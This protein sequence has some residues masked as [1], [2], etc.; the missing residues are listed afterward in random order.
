MHDRTH[1][2]RQIAAECDVLCRYLTGRHPTEHVRAHYVA[3]HELASPANP[4]ESETD[5]LLVR[6]ARA[7]PRRA[8]LAD[9]CAAAFVRNCTLRRKVI[10]LLAILESAAP[11]SDWVDT[12]T[13]RSR[14]RLVA[15]VAAG[16]TLFAL[17]AL[18]GASLIAVLGVGARL[19]T[20]LGW[21]AGA[22]S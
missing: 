10:L 11:S 22:S 9:A 5:L 2:A 15:Q 17:K 7:G 19:G 16:A 13:I 18:V 12:V 3:A 8:A 1:D 20:K 4:R 14:W 6:L 21:P